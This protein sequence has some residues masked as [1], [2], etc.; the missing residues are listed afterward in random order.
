MSFMTVPVQVTPA[1]ASGVPAKLF[2]APSLVLDGR[3]LGSTARTYDIS[4]DGKRFLMLQEGS[5]SDNG[6]ASP[7]GIVVVQNW[8]EEL[9]AKLRS[10]AP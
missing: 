4:P 6:L 2:D 8:L 1:F 5:L 10:T 7:F 9:Q 3:F